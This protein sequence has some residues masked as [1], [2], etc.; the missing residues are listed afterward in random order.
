[1]AIKKYQDFSWW[2][3]LNDSSK[4]GDNEF[5]IAK[6]VNYNNSRQLQTRRGYRKFGNP[7]GA[8]PITS[9]FYWQH[10]SNLDRHAIC[11]SWWSMYKYDESTGDWSAIHTDN[12]EFEDNVG[13]TGNRTR[14]DFA[15]YKNVAYMCNGVNPYSSFDWTTFTHIGLGVA[16]ACTFD[17]S[18]DYVTS[19]WHWL[20]TN[21]EVIFELDGGTLPAEVAVHRVYV[22]T[23][24]SNNDFQIS[25]YSWWP[26]LNFTDNGTATV[27]FQK[28]NQPSVRYIQYLGD[29]IYAA[30]DDQ[31]PSTLYYTWAA[32]TDGNNI[33]AN[34]VVVWWDENG[35]VNWLNQYSQLVLVFKSDKVYSVNVATPSVDA[36]DSQTGWYSDRSIHSVGNTLAYFNERGIDTLTKRSG[37]GWVSGIESK[38]LSDNVRA[39]LENITEAQYNSC[40]WWYVKKL[41]NFYFSFDTNNDNIPDTTLVYSSSVWSWTQ[42]TIPNLY[43]YGEYVN[44][45]NELQMLFA[46][47]LGGQM[48]QFEYWFDDDGEPIEVELQTKPFDFDD[49]AQLKVFSFVDVT[50]YKQEGWNIDISLLVD[51]DVVSMWSI[52]DSNI[53]TDAP[54]WILG[55]DA[56]GEKAL[57]WPWSEWLQL[58]PFTVRLKIYERGSDIAVKLSSTGV[59]RVLDKIRVWVDGEVKTMFSYDNII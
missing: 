15:V 31:N 43:D 54:I 11:A 16:T 3:N 37:V 21:D 48:Y 32:P 2:L 56:I 53:E 52:T 30:W 36:I 23:K 46:S 47:A 44:S 41:N 14:R 59:Q 4:I 25:T 29:R 34:A 57:W 40:V 12:S 7:I 45:D 27:N 51:D 1:M 28:V 17:S 58:Y 22:V 6:N 42:Y 13:V 24:I 5:V 26:V 49:P 18:T 9:Y 35:V 10:D 38:P 19:A 8:A 20:E 55:I 39:L 50:G 33:G